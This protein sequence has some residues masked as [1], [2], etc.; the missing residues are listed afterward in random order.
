MVRNILDHVIFSFVSGFIGLFVVAMS[1][2]AF[3]ADILD[4]KAKL[5]LLADRPISLKIVFGFF[6]LGCAVTILAFRKR[7]AFELLE[8]R[9]LVDEGELKKVQLTLT[10]LRDE[11]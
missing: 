11:R 7:R 2:Y 9:M 5:P 6:I 10:T 4:G 3:M 1:A 8:S